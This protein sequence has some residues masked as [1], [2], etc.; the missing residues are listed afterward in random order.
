MRPAR[1]PIESEEITSQ[2]YLMLRE[3]VALS[4]NDVAVP[5]SIFCA[6]M[7]AGIDKLHAQHLVLALLDIGMVHSFSSEMK[8]SLTARGI[9]YCEHRKGMILVRLWHAHPEAFIR[10]CIGAMGA[11]VGSFATLLIRHCVTSLK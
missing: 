6:A 9:L 8:V 1:Q 7:K 3:L 11:I 2:Q 4:D 10:G 5:V